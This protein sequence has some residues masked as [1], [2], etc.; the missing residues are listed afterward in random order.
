[1]IRKYLVIQQNRQ[2]VILFHET[3]PLRSFYLGCVS[4]VPELRLVLMFVH[5]GKCWMFYNKKKSG[6]SYCI[7]TLGRGHRQYCYSY[8]YSLKIDILYNAACFEITL[9]V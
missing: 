3:I 5:G 9:V 1:M 2:N 6:Q 4:L 7:L 8:R